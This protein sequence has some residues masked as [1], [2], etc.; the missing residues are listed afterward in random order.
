[1]AGGKFRQSHLPN[2][3]LEGALEHGLME[4]VAP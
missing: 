3:G 1:V 2:S 4:V